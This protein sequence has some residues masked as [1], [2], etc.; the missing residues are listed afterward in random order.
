[1]S[2]RLMQYDEMS[3][4]PRE[5]AAAA[6]ERKLV[7][8]MSGDV[9][10][11]SRLMGDDDVATVETLRTYREMITVTV[12][13][14]GGRLVDFT[15]DNLLAT[16][17]STVAA[18]ECAAVLQ[19]GLAKRNA[20][21]AEPRRMAF[22]LGV[23]LGEVIVDGERIYGDG[24]NLAA[25]LQGLAPPGGVYVSAAVHEQVEKKLALA[26]DCVG[27]HSVKNIEKPVVVYCMRAPTPETDATTSAADTPG[28][29]KDASMAAMPSPPA[30]SIAVLPF[31][32]LTDDPASGPF[33]VGLT[34]DLVTDLAKLPKVTVVA[35]PRQ[36]SGSSADAIASQTARQQLG[37]RYLLEGRVRQ[38]EDT[39]RITAQLVEVATGHH[40]WGE[41]YDRS[42]G[43]I[44]AVQDEVLKS[45]IVGIQ[46]AVALR[47][48]ETA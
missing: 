19:D 37:A 40:V 34:E 18:V 44:F 35:V 3:S 43:D 24:V 38:V 22:R 33:V 36:A 31:E 1:M 8:I 13:H 25:R 14:H 2:V 23:N 46:A 20:E 12:D 39:V 21:L 29:A 32:D 48:A 6:V 41:R 16:F 45:V 5:E 9:A 15:G 11:Y 17:P 7:A 47:E 30:R 42:L 27:E 26:F 28:P 10:G 4:D